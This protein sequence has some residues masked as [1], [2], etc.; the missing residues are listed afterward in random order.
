MFVEAPGTMSFCL[1]FC[2][3]HVHVCVVCTYTEYAGHVYAWSHT[4]V[5][6]VGL[7]KNVCWKVGYEVLCSICIAMDRV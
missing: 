5:V 7:R 2:N 6:L 3:V 1:Q 4:H